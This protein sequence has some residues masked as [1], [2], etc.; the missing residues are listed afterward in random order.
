MEDASSSQSALVISHILAIVEA[1]VPELSTL[2]L[3]P[4]LIMITCDDSAK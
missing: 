4:A 3:A 1:F 2:V